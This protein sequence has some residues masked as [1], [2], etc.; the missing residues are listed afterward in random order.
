[1]EPVKAC[2][3]VV[4]EIADQPSVLAFRHPLAG[5]Q[6]VKGTITAHEP[7]ELAAVRELREEAGVTATAVMDLG[8]WHSQHGDQV[9]SF[10]LCRPSG[11]LPDSWTHWCED[12]GGHAFEF[13]WQPLSTDSL[14][15]WHPVHARALEFVRNAL[16]SRL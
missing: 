16:T 2:A 7:P 10:H 12:D 3:I 13:F 6:L 15:E 14:V 4:R 8:T 5:C 11:D 1:M 9:W